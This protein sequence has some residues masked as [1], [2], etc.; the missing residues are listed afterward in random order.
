M[1]APKPAVEPFDPSDPNAITFDWDNAPPF[2]EIRD[3]DKVTYVP[4]PDP[5]YRTD[6][7]HPHYSPTADA[8]PAP[9]PPSDRPTVRPSDPSLPSPIP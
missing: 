3:G 8:P 5:I 9:P 2:V 4:R 1:N 6:P 7:R